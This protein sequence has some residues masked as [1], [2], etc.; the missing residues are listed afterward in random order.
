MIS[1]TALKACP[2]T[3]TKRHGRGACTPCIIP[4]YGHKAIPNTHIM[5]YDPITATLTNTSWTFPTAEP[6]TT[7]VHLT[8]TL[9]LTQKLVLTLTLTRTPIVG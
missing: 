6:V 3:L 1:S 8:L 4:I 2:V 7:T 5:S 9:I